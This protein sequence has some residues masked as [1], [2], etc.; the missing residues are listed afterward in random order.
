[1]ARGLRFRASSAPP[2]ARISGADGGAEG[3]GQGLAEALDVGVVFGF[4][5]DTGQLL[6]AGI[7]ENNAAIFAEGGLS[8]G[9]RA[10]NFWK[11]FERRLGFYFH[12]DD[13]LRVVLEALDKRFD[14]TAHGNKRSDF[15]GGK[16]AIT[17]RT[18]FQKNDVAGL[19]AA[20]DIAAAKH[21]FEHVAIADGGAGQRDAFAGEDALEA[22]IGHGRGDD[23]VPFELVL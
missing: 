10:G 15:Y 13:G 14:F 4:D 12:V 11:S 17:R 7:A 9:E 16:K 21:F 5:H 20:D 8:F 23:A 19:F 18:I 3:V 2:S 22:E 6:C 1:M